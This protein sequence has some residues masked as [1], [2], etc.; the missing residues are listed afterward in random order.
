VVVHELAGLRA[1]ADV[2]CEVLLLHVRVQHAVVVEA[3]AAEPTRGVPCEYTAVGCDCTALGYEFTAMG[4]AFTAWG[5][6]FTATG[7]EFTA[8][9]CEFTAIRCATSPSWI[10]KTSDVNDKLV[11][12]GFRSS[13][14]LKMGT[15]WVTCYR[16]GVRGRGKSHRCGEVTHEGERI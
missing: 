1:L 16:S 10:R 5:C 4:C 2:A 9:G 11:V 6:A 14:V 12:E 13:Y 3:L 7:C 8:M 15:K